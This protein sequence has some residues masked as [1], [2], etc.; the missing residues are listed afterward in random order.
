MSKG[1]T[2]LYPPHGEVSFHDIARIH[3]RCIG[4][5]HAFYRARWTAFGKPGT[6]EERMFTLST[7]EV[8]RL[9]GTSGFRGGC[10]DGVASDGRYLDPNFLPHIPFGDLAHLS[11]ERN[12]GAAR[13]AQE[14]P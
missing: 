10:V 6:V 2:V 7:E 1:L 5:S 9:T 4:K 8:K 14:W 12:T 3:A 13:A 11:N